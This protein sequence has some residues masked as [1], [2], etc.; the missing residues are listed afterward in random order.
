[1]NAPTGR[2]AARLAAL[3]AAVRGALWMFLGVTGL[4]FTALLVKLL[5]GNLHAF[6]IG[7]FRALFGLAVLLPFIMR[8]GGAVLRTRRLPTHIAR[9][10]L[11]SIAMLAGFL[12]VTLLPL[13]DAVA[14]SFTKPLFVVLLAALV[15]RE[16]VRWRRWSATA[17]GFVG[18]LIMVRPGA[19]GFDPAIA[20]ALLSAFAAGGAWTFIKSLSG[21]EAPVTMLS[22]FAIISSVVTLAAA[23]PVWQTPTTVELLILLGMGALGVGG[24][25]AI[26]RAFR[27]ADASAVAPLDYLRLPIAGGLAFIVFAEL[28]S[29]QNL[30]GA[31]VII[32]STIY[33]AR[34]EAALQKPPMPPPSTVA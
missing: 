3:P 32:A 2:L 9:T 19:A 25:A 23:V 17:V 6:Q 5:G 31:V 4:S 34:R 21:T 18:V 1:M 24:Q 26:I 10:I 16:A 20:I 12:A 28:P 15:L 8:D 14:L 29:I 7:F 30:I 33:I 27:V 11:G 22:W 13:A